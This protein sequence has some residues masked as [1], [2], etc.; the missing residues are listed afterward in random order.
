MVLRCIV[1]FMILRCI[2]QSDLNDKMYICSIRCYFIAYFELIMAIAIML[3]SYHLH[4]SYLY[5]SMGLG[6]FLI[7]QSIRPTIEN[8]EGSKVMLVF[9]NTIS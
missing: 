1:Q 7:R 6:I 8:R 4:P 5:C 3:T 9:G 2:V